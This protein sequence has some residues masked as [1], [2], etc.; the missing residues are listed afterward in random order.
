MKFF[1]QLTVFLG[2]LT[3]AFGAL[4]YHDFQDLTIPADSAGIYVNPVTGATS[5]EVP[6]DYATA[7]W[8]N[9]FFSGT[10]IGSTPFI[11]PAITAPATGN[12]DGLILKIDYQQEVGP[13][14]EFAEGFNGSENH[15]GSGSGQFQFGVPAAIGFALSTAAEG[16]VSYGWMSIT[17]SESG[18][19]ILHGSAYEDTP[20]V[21]I[22]A[23]SVPEPGTSALLLLTSGAFL[24]R[25]R[26]I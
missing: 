7:P 1:R 18:T 25:R 2:T 10:A 5:T 12:G 13:T 24:L 21:P 23:G 16:P 9:L 20:G 14:L 17:I 19:G 11:E 4:H 6:T 22:L 15:T 3:P 8:L 26:R